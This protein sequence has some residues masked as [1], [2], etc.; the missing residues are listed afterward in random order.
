MSSRKGSSNSF[1]IGNK[2]EAIEE[3]AKI[4]E[5]KNHEV[6]SG[7]HPTHPGSESDQNALDKTFKTAKEPSTVPVDNWQ[8]FVICN[9]DTQKN[10]GK[11]WWKGGSENPSQQFYIWTSDQEENI[12]QDS[13]EK[14]VDT[15]RTG[16]KPKKSRAEEIKEEAKEEGYAFDITKQLKLGK[17]EFKRDR[18]NSQPVVS[19]KK[20]KKSFHLSQLMTINSKWED[21]IN[22]SLNAQL[23]E[24]NDTNKQEDEENKVKDDPDFFYANIHD[25]P[26]PRETFKMISKCS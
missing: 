18:V 6:S 7:L 4:T 23:G 5:L 2:F 3:L 21:D 8:K 15:S 10:K 20:P 13:V 11:C 19:P 24:A 22:L 12:Q 9:W 16:A 14:K 1:K 26:I 17:K 25:N